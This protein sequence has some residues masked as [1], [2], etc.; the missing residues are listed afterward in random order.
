MAFYQ[1]L[2]VDRIVLRTRAVRM[3]VALGLMWLVPVLVHADAVS[4]P[5]VQLWL[6]T[7]SLAGMRYYDGRQVWSQ[8]REGDGLL[9]VREPGNSWD[10]LAIAVAWHDHKLGYVPRRENMAL[11]RLMDHGTV[12]SARIVRLVQQGKRRKKLMFDVYESLAPGIR[13]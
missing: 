1:L 2:S 10:H 13:P 5:V 3:A 9:L 4:H 7:S 11:A 8:M 6:Q 12:L